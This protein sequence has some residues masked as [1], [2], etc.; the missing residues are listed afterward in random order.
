MRGV[1]AP[2][3][4]GNNIVVGDK[5]GYLHWLDRKTGKL[6]AQQLIDSDGLFSKALNSDEYLY[7]QSRGGDLV[8]VKKPI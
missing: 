6:V 3:V 4:S 1:T 8:A 2:T 7:V 5:E